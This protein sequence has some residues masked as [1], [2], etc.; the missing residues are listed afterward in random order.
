M[1][2]RDIQRLKKAIEANTEMLKRL[3]QRIDEVDS[4]IKDSKERGKEIRE[5]NAKEDKEK[6]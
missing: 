4:H 1:P 5:Q 6:R 3:H 2:E